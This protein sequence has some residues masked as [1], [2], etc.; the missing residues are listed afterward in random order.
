MCQVA[1]HALD[2]GSSMLTFVG[3][4]AFCGLMQPATHIALHSSPSIVLMPGLYC[5][6]W[7]CILNISVHLY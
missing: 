3:S 4:L 1:G 2:L 7:Q 5:I 6:P